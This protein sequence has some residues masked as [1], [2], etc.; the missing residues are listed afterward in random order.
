MKNKCL[1]LILLINIIVTTFCF[2]QLDNKYSDAQMYFSIKPPL[3]WIVAHT[4]IPHKTKVSFYNSDPASAYFRIYIGI[5]QFTLDSLYSIYQKTAINKGRIIEIKKKR[6]KGYD[7]II[8][9]FKGEEYG[10][11]IVDFFIQKTHH[12]LRYAANPDFFD[13]YLPIILKSIK[14]YKP[15][16]PNEERDWK[17]AQERD[18][19]LDYRKFLYQYSDSKYKIQAEE[20]ISTLLWKKTVNQCTIEDYMRFI[21]IYPTSS[22]SNLAKKRIEQMKK[23]INAWEQTLIADSIQTYQK[24]LNQHPNSLYSIKAIQY[25]KDIQKYD[26][27]RIEDWYSAY[28]AYLNEYPDGKF[29]DTARSRLE[30][31][32]SHKAE[33]SVDYP[34]S[35]KGGSS[36]YSNVSSPFFPMKITFYE[37]G[38]KVGYKITG[39]G[40]LYDNIGDKWGTNGYKINRGE[41]IIKPGDK[42]IDDY[43]CS[44]K[45]FIYGYA[46][47]YWEGEDAGGHPIK[48]EVKIYLK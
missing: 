19:S 5:E 15:T 30:W 27:A 14:T 47:F 11:Y 36:P 22:N 7:A 35:V 46:H 23:D 28:E 3:N 18:D 2:G 38:C 34:S 43:W 24:F 16:I 20:N 13:M 44:G 6:F 45:R 21:D 31:L 26:S 29:A 8:T 37:S 33:F 10:C 12:K 4:Y 39:S 1:Y 32:K 40:W 41:L 42:N 25:I 9:T 48:I 17:Y